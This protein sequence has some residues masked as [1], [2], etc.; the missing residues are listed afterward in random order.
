MVKKIEKIFTEKN[1]V[2]VMAV[3]FFISLIP[4]VLLATYNFP[5]ADD[6]SASDDVRLAWM[7]TGSL[8]QVLKAAWE[9][10]VFNYK[11]WSGVYMSVFW[12]SLQPGIFGEKFYCITTYI[13]LFLLCISVSYLGKVVFSKY[14]PTDK[15]KAGCVAICFLFT[16]IQCMPSGN[17]GLFWHPGTANYTWAFAFLL[18]LL[19]LMLS[20]YKE[21]R[22]NAKIVKCVSACILSVFVGGGN[23]ITALQGCIWLI[24][25]LVVIGAFEKQKLKNSGKEILKKNWTNVIPVITIL[26]AF[27]ASVLAPGNSVRIASSSGMNPLKAVVVSFYECYTLLMEEWISF[28]MVLLIALAIPFM[29]KIT[30]ECNFKFSYPGVIAIGA[31]AFSSAAFT[32]SLYAQGSIDAGRLQNTAFFILLLMLYILTFYMVGWIH[33]QVEIK[34]ENRTKKSN[35]YAAGMLL[36]F[37]FTLG[38]SIKAEKD[39]LIAS[40]AMFNIISG[41][42]Q[43]YE[44]QNEERLSMYLDERIENVVV[45]RFI[46]PPLLL[47]FQDNT[48]EPGEWINQVVAK[49]YGKESV[50]SEEYER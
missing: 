1:I 27:G 30:G 48:P 14:F 28:P 15:Y 16:L 39:T 11:E 34:E 9:N 8:W 41:E 31:Y 33:A 22:K 7:S 24:T 2:I 43:N 21:E 18:I 4:I 37:V 49:Y 40:E 12:T 20:V 5:C 19:A 38:M 45:E 47:H 35:I 46:N 17:E 44:R 50:R 10:V 32:P 6:F 26:C 13:T 25:M 29:W 36:F 23:Y 3:G 42:A